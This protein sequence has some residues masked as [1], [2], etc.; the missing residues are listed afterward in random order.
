[1]PPHTLNGPE[2]API[3]GKATS[4]VIFLHGLGS[5]GHDLI[6]LAEDLAPLLPHTHFLS[7]DAPFPY[8]AAGFGY[9]WFDLYERTESAMLAGIGRATPILNSYIDSQLARFGLKDNDLALVGFSQGTMMALHTALRRPEACAAVLGF[10]GALL[11]P[12]LLVNEITARPE[13]MLIHGDADQVV[14]PAAL[15]AATN[16]LKALNV[17]VTSHLIH[18]MAHGINGK[19]LHYGAAFLKQKLTF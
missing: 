8:A 7:P 16:S 18:G 9:E 10:S 3:S 12:Q 2:K 6:E 19:A 13:I 17:P 14:P 1:M 5:N 15:P 4:L 11:A